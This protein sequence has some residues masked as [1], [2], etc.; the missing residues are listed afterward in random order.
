[1]KAGSWEG[2]WSPNLKLISQT[3][4]MKVEVKVADL[5]LNNYFCKGYAL[6]VA[7]W[8]NIAYSFKY[9]GLVKSEGLPL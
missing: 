9:T 2:V 1:M 8:K 4:L 3:V 5:M 6:L 7:W